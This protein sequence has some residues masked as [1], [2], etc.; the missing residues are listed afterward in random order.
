MSKRSPH[1]KKGKV[2]FLIKYAQK[3]LRLD[4]N[5]TRL[6]PRVIAC[7]ECGLLIIIDLYIYLYVYKLDT[8]YPPGYHH[9]GSEATR[10]LRTHGVRYL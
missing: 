6:E 10:V 4:R 2:E 5:S 7:N 1:C 9:S 8:I 3:V